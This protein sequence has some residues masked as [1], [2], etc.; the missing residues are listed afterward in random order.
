MSRPRT[1]RL[2]VLALAACSGKTTA[3][4]TVVEDARGTGSATASHDAGAPAPAPAPGGKGDVQIRVEW[5]DVPADA[6]ATPGRTACG[7]PRPAAVAPT[8]VWGIPEVFVMIDAPGTAPRTAQRI[9]LAGCTLAPR[10]VVTHGSITIASASDAPATLAIQRAGALPLGGALADD[11]R[12]DVY[13][14]IAGH[15]VSIALDAGGNYRIG[16]AEDAWLVASDSP[17]VAVTDGSG[18][19]VLRG[20]PTGTHEVIAWLPARSGQSARVARAKVNVTAGSLTDVTV[21]LTKQ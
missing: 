14:P 5:K 16:G 18:T 2:L 3:P 17:F 15:S 19:A 20:I 10:A 11:K 9:A 6:R 21:D 1:S 12:R 7:T 13:L 4:K 8:T